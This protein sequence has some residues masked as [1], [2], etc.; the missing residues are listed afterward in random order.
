[1]INNR[2]N[3]GCR[4]NE[5]L[6]YKGL[7]LLTMEN[8]ILKISILVD[9]GTDII[10][11]LYKPKDIDFM[12]ISPVDFKPGE[13]DRKNFL[14]GYLGGWQEIIPNGGDSCVYKGAGFNLH[15]ETPQLSWDYEILENTSEKI[16]IKFFVRLNKMPLYIEKIINMKS[17]EA[18]IS[19]DESVS[20]LGNENLDFMWGHHPCFGEPFLSDSCLI[21]FKAEEI[22]SSIDSISEN[23]LVKPN[24]TGT[25]KDFPGID[26]KSVDLSKV[27]DKKSR[28]TDLLYVNKLSENWFSLT[29]ISKK[30]GI[31]YVFNKSIFK[32]LYF[33]LVYGGSNNYPW[34]GNTYNLAIEPWSSWPGRGLIEAIKNNTSLKISPGQTIDSWLKVVVYEKDQ[35][36]NKIKDNCEVL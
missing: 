6:L 29:N 12:W 11:L 19:I 4:F 31:G 5:E 13:F 34:F 33:W 9:K 15:D 16:S 23:P 21:D 35:N 8:E 27:L 26:G 32:Y 28:A 25:L 7:R 22:T 10:E 17:N 18:S 14:E 3:H 2:R 1:M 24:T 20:N 36:V 30:I